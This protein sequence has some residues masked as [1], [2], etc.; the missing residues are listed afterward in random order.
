M[1]LNETPT[2]IKFQLIPQRLLPRGYANLYVSGV[3]TK[4]SARLDDQ[5]KLPS[6]GS[7]QERYRLAQWRCR[8]PLQITH[9]N[10]TGKVATTGISY[11]ETMSNTL[12]TGVDGPEVTIAV[13]LG[14]LL[15]NNYHR[16]TAS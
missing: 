10:A 16:E 1:K 4:V 15:G 11:L 12:T 3:G 8:P 7:L 13:R 5:W 9:A 14:S 2:H 6:N